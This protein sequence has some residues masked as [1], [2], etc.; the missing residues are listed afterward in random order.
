MKIKTTYQNL[1]DTAEAVLGEKF[2]IQSAYIRKGKRSQ[3]YTLASTLRNWK[4]K[5]KL[6][7]VY[8]EER[9]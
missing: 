9:K 2:I 7:P 4:G 1:Y 5:S 6:S 8:A 3:M